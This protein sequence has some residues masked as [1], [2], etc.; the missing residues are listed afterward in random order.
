MAH[1]IRAAPGAVVLDIKVSAPPRF[2]PQAMDDLKTEIHEPRDGGVDAF[3]ALSRCITAAKLRKRR[4][5][6][7]AT[8][9]SASQAEEYCQSTVDP[10]QGGVLEMAKNLAEL[11]TQRRLRLVHHDLRALCKAVPRILLDLDPPQWDIQQCAGDGKHRHRRS[12]AKAVSLHH[13]CRARLSQIALQGDNHHVA[14]P[15]AVQPAVSDP[16]DQISSS[17][18]L[19]DV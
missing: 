9:L 19:A 3:V 12:S 16:S 7:R 4:H 15:H 1:P 13:Q 17:T 10:K 8:V 6:Y 5:G 11:T 18:W 2:K 14:M